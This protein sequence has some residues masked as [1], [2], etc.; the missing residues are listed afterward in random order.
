MKTKTTPKA[1]ANK[2]V[3]LFFVMGL[4][5]LQVMFAFTIHGDIGPQFQPAADQFS[6]SAQTLLGKMETIIETTP[7]RSSVSALPQSAPAGA[8]KPSLELGVTA[9]APAAKS[10]AVAPSEESGSRF[11][12]YTVHQGDSL[13]TIS[14]KL[15][16]RSGMSTALARLNRISD[17]KA[18]RCGQVLRVPR[19]G[20]LA[21]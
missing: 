5:L 4:F 20:L 6:P 12:E 1:P 16:G 10:A 3:F 15:Y 9:Q 8:I 11:F 14:R 21:N 19:Q 13:H 2:G 18:L 17:E 7:V